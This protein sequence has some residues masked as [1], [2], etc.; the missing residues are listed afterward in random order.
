MD[1]T[2]SG[3]SVKTSWPELLGIPGVEAKSRILADNPKLKVIIL[4]V[5]SAVTEDLRN[6]RV[7]V[8]VDYNEKVAKIPT[9]G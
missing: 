4:P 3:T 5:R 7:R 2:N 6:D 1:E 9:I 8:F